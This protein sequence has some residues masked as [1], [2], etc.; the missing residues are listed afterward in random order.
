M[1]EIAKRITI[2]KKSSLPDYVYLLQN[3][4]GEYQ[5]LTQSVAQVNNTAVIDLHSNI[6]PTNMLFD[7]STLLTHPLHSLFIVDK[8]YS[9]ISFND[10]AAAEL[11]KIKNKPLKKGDSVIDLITPADLDWFIKD[12]EK[13]TQG[14]VVNKDKAVKDKNG[15]TYFFTY[16]Y[17]PIRSG[18]SEVDSICISIINITQQKQ[19]LSKIISQEH[20]FATILNNALSG[21]LLYDESEAIIEVN[22][23]TLK[24]FD[25]NREELLYKKRNFIIEY[26]E[27]FIELIKQRD[28]TGSVKGEAVGIKKDGTRFPI[29][30]SS[31]I[32]NDTYNNTKYFCSVINDI[33]QRKQVEQRIK[34][35][36]KQLEELIGN[37]KAG[38]VVHRADT[39]IILAN[40]EA[41]NLLGLTHDQML[42][43]EALDPAWCFRYED[44][45]PMRLEDYPVNKVIA[46][47]NA[48]KDYIVIVDRPA[49]NDSVWVIANSFPELDE[50]ANIINVV[51]TF[52]D[53][54]TIKTTEKLLTEV[55]NMAKIGA[56][57]VDLINSTVIWND[58]T[59]EIHQ[60]HTFEKLTIT[61]AIHFYKEGEH[62]N[63]VE[64]KVIE[65]IDNGT[66]FDFEA[67][68]I[69]A[70]GKECWVRVTGKPDF[71]QNKCVRIFGVIQ[72]IN[73]KKL[74]ELQLLEANKTITESNERFE[75]VTQ[76]TFDAIWDWDLETN[77]FFRGEGFETLFGNR[78][79]EQLH[80]KISWNVIHPEDQAKIEA[81]IQKAC[82]EGSPTWQD[83]YRFLKS[84]NTY[85]FVIDKAVIIRNPNGKAIRMIGAMHDITKIKTEEE[86]RRL[87]ESVVTNSNDV[88]VITE[89]EPFD[90]PGPKIVYVNQ[91]FLKHTGYTKE[92]VIGQTP[93]LLQGPKT[94][95]K[96]LAYLKERLQQWLPTT[97]EL[98]NY[99]KN[100]EEFWNEFTVIPV[101]N[102]HGWFTHWIAVER[103]ITERKKNELEK[104]QLIKELTKTNTELKQFSYITSH[105][106]RAPLT[107]LLAILSLFDTSTIKDV[108]TVELIDAM[109]KSTNQL[110]ETLNELIKVL[111]IKENTNKQLSSISFAETLE[112]V[113]QSI[114]AIIEKSECVIISDFKEAPTVNFD[115]TYLESI[116]LNLITNAIKYAHPNRNPVIYITST[117]SNA[118]IQLNVSDN[119]IGFN[120]AK[121]K[122]KIF[123][124]YQRFHNH[125]DSKGFGLYLIHAQVTSLGG[126]I[127]VNSIENEGT[128]F[129]INFND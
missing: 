31:V 4:I 76:A 122:G 74:A 75:Y 82:D 112:Q 50:N 43:K 45:T 88:I 77:T 62:R 104:E 29:E 16:N 20:T 8:N 83:E 86:Q 102:E 51:V 13:A 21:L 125:P 118:G 128:R 59:K 78:Y 108:A 103:D 40:K 73:E 25:Y 52:I 49:T 107:N 42:G 89:A 55:T 33:T 116:L 96:V 38:V 56:W 5:K 80:S 84:D 110:N 61:D 93:R 72:N 2:L 101:A 41:E 95:K 53:V 60:L 37:L 127:N 87:L 79:K 15:N 9:I 99:K 46:T 119:G 11:L 19:I 81:S 97:V 90:L 7:D 30:F 35:T 94:D 22:D 63:R 57:E 39:S 54:T 115:K 91:A 121:V 111:I 67:I 66:P 129:L 85:A 3:N 27:N 105:N 14:F 92:E 124:L 109:H 114:H 36:N 100:Q 28:A 69:T 64:Q 32:V 44:G 23:A 24:Q 113:Q 70:T 65:A 71:V 123:G 6:S 120:M 34:Q 10:T 1:F 68:I 48:I 17:V 117:K 58:I 47:K 98:I 18:S 106:L 26:S 12:F 126:T